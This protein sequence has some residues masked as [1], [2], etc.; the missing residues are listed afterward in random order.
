M[1]TQTRRVGYAMALVIAFVVST[2]SAQQPP[3]TLDELERAVATGAAGAATRLELARVYIERERFWEARAL[4]REL[5]AETAADPDVRTL[6]RAAEE[7]LD[8]VQSERVA[9][10]ERTLAN[11]NLA[12]AQRREAANTL[13]EAG[14]YAAAAQHYAL[15]PAS[16]LDRQTRLRRAR[17]LAWSGQLDAAERVYH[18][19]R[20]ERTDPE[21]NLEYG[22]L[23]SWMGAGR[24]S[25]E[26]LEAAYAG[27]PSH[28]GAVALANALAWSGQRER[29]LQFLQEHVGI[30]GSAPE[31]SALLTEL[32][33][34]RELALER[35]DRRIESEPFNLSLRLARAELLIEAGR[36]AA[37][38]EELERVDRHSSRADEILDHLRSTA[39][40]RRDAELATVEERRRALDIREASNADAILELARAYSGLAEYDQARRL[41]SRYLDLRP[42]D[43]EA[44]LAYARV[45]QWDR[46][47]AASANQYEI[48]LEAEPDRAD[49]RLE[50]ARVLSW[51]KRF[52][53][54]IDAL[55][56]LTS[57]DGNPRAHLYPEVPLEARFSLGQIYRWFGWN[58][59]AVEY[60]TSALDMDSAFEPSRQELDILRHIRP[61]TVWDARYT[62]YENSS[63]FQ[64]DRID[65]EME[66]WTSQRSSWTLGIG[67]HEF[68]RGEADYA[69]TA[70]GG[71]FR[72]RYTDQFTPR[73]RLGANIYDGD[74]G[75]RL[76]WNLGADWR[77]SLQTRTSL[78]YAHYDLVYDVHNTRALGGDPLEIDDLRAHYD[79]H[80]GGAWSWLAQASYG[81]ISDDNTRLGVHGL[82]TFR[83]LSDPY[84]A[85]KGDV[86][87]LEH[88]F[89][90]PRYWSPTDYQ[91]ATAV[92]HVG[93]DV[94]QRFFWEAELK[95][96]RAWEGDFE[97]DVRA[98]EARVTV[99]VS[100]VLDIVGNWA[101]GESGRLEAL[102]GGDDFVNY[103]QNR[104]FVG[105]RLKRRYD[106]ADRRGAQPYYFDDSALEGSTILPPEVR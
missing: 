19:L 28:Q 54:A 67:R 44:R 60:Q 61:A 4:L 99:P 56:R 89:R 82:L 106:D 95:Y 68:D 64:M 105:I 83:I 39:R 9:Q 92:L 50:H 21:L 58:E 73:A 47:Y 29:A 7:G 55:E 23:L 20:S 49:V 32:T 78:E 66:K 45:L 2:L 94:R 40:E 13:F 97:S 3:G 65:L 5:A 88:D 17:A 33:E 75:T 96:G 6:L 76:W 30:H 98:I 69:A 85:V 41:Y 91:S 14:Q 36:Y 74:P 24:A 84:V 35:L 18:E 100:D 70:I 101:Y 10:A 8:R 57:I 1:S 46:R 25:V 52:V 31:T 26:S 27:S 34:G 62:H 86:R 22:R 11:R 16:E 42:D 93:D 102:P 90:S 53:P 59:H 63:D 80:T 48:V 79:H 81:R 72:Y 12:P 51:D 104:F 37:A 103:W 77:P 43:L 38:L 71:G 15:L 87:Y